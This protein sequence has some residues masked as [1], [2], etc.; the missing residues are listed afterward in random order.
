MPPSLTKDQILKDI[1]SVYQLAFY[2]G[3]LQVT[4]RAKELQGRAIGLFKSQHLPDNL[5][6]AD[7]TEEQLGDFIALLEKHHPELKNLEPPETVTSGKG[8]PLS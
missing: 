6:I 7:M 2:S 1:E 5:C 8:A 4:L 3:K